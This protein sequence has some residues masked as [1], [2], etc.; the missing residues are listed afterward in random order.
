ML[1]QWRV[2]LSHRVPLES[3]L[4]A[5]DRFYCPDHHPLGRGHLCG[6]ELRL[7]KA[8][9][10]NGKLSLWFCLGNVVS[11]LIILP[12]SRSGHPPPGLMLGLLL[13]TLNLPLLI[14]TAT[15]LWLTFKS[16]EEKP[17]Y[18]LV[19]STYVLLN[20]LALYIVPLIASLVWSW[21]GAS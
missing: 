1:R 4:N 16:H 6:H 21:F 10:H 17:G 15:L 2:P 18:L 5:D 9:D 14:V 3:E 8:G 12:I 13:W 11:W 20:S 7:E 19:A